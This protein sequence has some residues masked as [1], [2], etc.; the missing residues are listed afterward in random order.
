MAT[1]R[2]LLRRAVPDDLGAILDYLGEKSPQAADRFAD[3]V[4]AALEKLSQFPGAG[5]LRKLRDAR[6]RG[7]RTWRIPGFKKYLIVYRPIEDGLEVLAILHGARNLR[8][9]LRERQ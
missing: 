3:A 1:P 9:R 4:P 8:A 6:L 2:V 7:V 5:S